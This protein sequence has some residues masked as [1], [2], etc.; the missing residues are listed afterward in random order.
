MEPELRRRDNYR[1]TPP[2]VKKKKKLR[3]D[4]YD[5]TV[6]IVVLIL[7]LFGVVM[8]YSASYYYAMTSEDFNYDMFRFLKR[9][10]VWA[11]L[12]LGA[13]IFVMHI[14]YHFWRRVA[15]WP[16]LFSNVCLVLVQ[17]VG[18]KINGQKRW[19]QLPPSPSYA[20]S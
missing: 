18:T 7:V 12:G 10:V 5:F 17:L 20:P 3:P 8:V 2:A 1:N 6:V 9:Q 14:P 16:Y 19:L 11:T 15:F 13:M 4:A